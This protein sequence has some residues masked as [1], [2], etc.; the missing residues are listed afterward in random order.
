MSTTTPKRE[1]AVGEEDMILIDNL[2]EETILT[3]IHL[4]F[5]HDLIYVCTGV[6]E[7]EKYQLTPFSDLHWQ[8]TCGWYVPYFSLHYLLTW[9]Q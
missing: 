6:R 7:K 8:H 2:S 9:H 1:G 4:R 3:N 5:V